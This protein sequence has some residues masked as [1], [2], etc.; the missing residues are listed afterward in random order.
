MPSFIFSASEIESTLSQ[1]HD[2][3]ILKSTLFSLLVYVPIA[4][5]LVQLFCWRRFTLH[6]EYL[7]QVRLPFAVVIMLVDPEE[8][9][10]WATGRLIPIEPLD[11]ALPL[12]CHLRTVTGVL[13]KP[14]S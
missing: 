5:A 14:S 1:E 2:P 11:N 3:A 8:D 9:S 13:A 6:G 4:C 10:I 12:Q 7:R